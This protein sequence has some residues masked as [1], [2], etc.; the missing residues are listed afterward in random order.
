MNRRR[1]MDKFVPP[2]VVTTEDGM[3][4]R[5][6][7]SALGRETEPRWMLLDADGVQYV[8]PV[9]E[10][11][12]SPEAVARLVSEWWKGVKATRPTDPQR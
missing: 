8:G 5:C 9:V 2:L 3:K 12:K 11:D 10:P 6:S 4:F 1:R 7:V